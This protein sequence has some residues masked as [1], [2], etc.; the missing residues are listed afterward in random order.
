MSN[1][2]RLIG[3]FENFTA[4]DLPRLGDFYASDATF[5]DPFNRNDYCK[6]PIAAEETSVLISHHPGTITVRLRYTARG[7]PWVRAA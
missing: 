4:A 2:L 1:A 7:D 6:Y 3:F 5:K